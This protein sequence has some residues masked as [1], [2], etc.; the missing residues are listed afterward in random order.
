MFCKALAIRV[1]LL[2]EA[3]VDVAQTY[4]NM[5]NVYHCKGDNVGTHAMYQKELEILSATLGLEHPRVRTLLETMRPVGPTELPPEV[6][7]GGCAEG[8]SR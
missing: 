7:P 8:C 2:G 6:S 5:A 1:L 3:H 4:D